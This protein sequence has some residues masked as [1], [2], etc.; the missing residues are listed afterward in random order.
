[1][2]PALS[3]S[4]TTKPFVFAGAVA[5]RQSVQVVPPS[6][7]I[8]RLM[9]SPP[10]MVLSHAKKATLL[11]GSYSIGPGK[12]VAGAPTAAVGSYVR[13]PSVDLITTVSCGAVWLYDISTV[14]S[15]RKVSHC[16]SAP[17]P[18]VVTPPARSPPAVVRLWP[19]LGDVAVAKPLKAPSPAYA[20]W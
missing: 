1:M 3:L 14:W 15:S 5:A 9:L 4:A 6:L 16:R 11:T 7:E 12:R 17:T 8:E 20:Y 19:L 13:P 2:L 18:C 10:V